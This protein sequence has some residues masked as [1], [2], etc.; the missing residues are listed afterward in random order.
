MTLVAG[1]QDGGGYGGTGLTVVTDVEEEQGH[2]ALCRARVHEEGSQGGIS[3]LRRE[4]FRA[5]SARPR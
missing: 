4:F 2:A 1:E 3:V 5:P